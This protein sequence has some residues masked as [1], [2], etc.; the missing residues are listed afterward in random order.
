M[1]ESG[2]LRLFVKDFFLCGVLGIDCSSVYDLSA[3][4]QTCIDV[5]EIIKCSIT[6]YILHI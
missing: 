1:A 2:L 5:I 4:V 6:F 3:S